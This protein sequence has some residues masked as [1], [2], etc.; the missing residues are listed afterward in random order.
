MNG[1]GAEGIRSVGV[2]VA[3]HMSDRAGMTRS[4]R[5]RIA[6]HDRGKLQDLARAYGKPE[7]GIIIGSGHWVVARTPSSSTN[8][9][10]VNDSID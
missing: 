4:K 9:G 8:R 3:L 10:R 6:I 7:L 5:S 2:T 1:T